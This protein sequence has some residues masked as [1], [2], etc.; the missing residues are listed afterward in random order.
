LAKQFYYHAFEVSVSIKGTYMFTSKSSINTYGYIYDDKFDLDDLNLN[1]ISQDDDSD[2]NG[3]FKM[4]TSLESGHRYILVA[5]T[6]SPEV[7]GEFSITSFG[8]TAVK[9]RS[10]TASRTVPERAD[11]K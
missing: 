1:L 11:S 9:I 6:N 4:I 8:P 2:G 10:K 5:T 7:M 3:Q